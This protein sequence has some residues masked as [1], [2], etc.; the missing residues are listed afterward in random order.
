MPFN[1]QIVLNKIISISF[2][3]LFVVT[4]TLPTVVFVIDDSIDVSYFNDFSEEE[5]EK[6]SEKNKELETL[7]EANSQE[8]DDFVLTEE[9][10]KIGYYFKNYQ[11]PHLNLISPPPDFS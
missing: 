10:N 2:I 1:F 11:K 5:E 6:G 8:L 9:K 7:F 4:I 3:F